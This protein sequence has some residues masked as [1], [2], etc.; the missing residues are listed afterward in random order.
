[1][2]KKNFDY[3]GWGIG[4]IIL[5]GLLYMFLG[6]KMPYEIDKEVN[7]QQVVNNARK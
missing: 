3:Q 5:V 1:M 2:S 6:F 7:Q 4:L